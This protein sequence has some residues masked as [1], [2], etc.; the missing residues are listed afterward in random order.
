[1]DVT[2]ATWIVGILG[3]LLMGLLMVVQTV[4]IIVP[5]GAWTIKNAYGGTPVTYTRAHD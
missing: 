1:M 4:A 2:L 5:R 3:L